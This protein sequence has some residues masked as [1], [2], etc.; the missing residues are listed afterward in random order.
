MSID[1]VRIKRAIPV[2]TSPSRKNT[3]RMRSDVAEIVQDIVLRRKT[4]TMI[5][6]RCAV[7]IE[8]LNRFRRKFITEEVKKVVLAEH[9]K[10]EAVALDAEVNAG[11]D[12]I[13]KGLADVLNE[14]KSL[15][16]LIKQKLNDDR[17][18]EDLLPSLQSLL[19]DQGQSFERM[20]KAYANLKDKTTITLT[21]NEHPDVA[22]LMDCLYVVFEAH[23]EAF[24]TFQGVL[25]DKRIP[26]D[27]A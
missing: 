9:Q 3:L 12:N 24:A 20:A 10:A 16:A 15:Y 22:K 27:V 13:Q 1:T 25:A 18:V 26:L 11:Q 17:D 23:P 14:Q 8:T 7:D 19:R 6:D 2:D 4:Y 21:L 5:A